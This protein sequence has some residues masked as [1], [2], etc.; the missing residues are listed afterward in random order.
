MSVRS[1]ALIE[2]CLVCHDLDTPMLIR[3]ALKQ[4]RCIL[5]LPPRTSS[6]MLST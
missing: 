5:T 1:K 3:H 2:P 4:Y 6:C